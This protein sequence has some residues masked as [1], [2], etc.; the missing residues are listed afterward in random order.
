M[1]VGVGNGGIRENYLCTG[2]VHCVE[3]VMAPQAR[4]EVVW[5]IGGS[6][7][8]FFWGLASDSRSFPKPR[9]LAWVT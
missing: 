9:T 8:V 6:G 1:S 4:E 5:G 2:D 7:R 3:A